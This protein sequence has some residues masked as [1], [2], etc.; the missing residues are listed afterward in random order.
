MNELGFLCTTLSAFVI[1]VT[2]GKFMFVTFLKPF[3]LDIENFV[4]IQNLLHNRS[5]DLY[6]LF[7]SKSF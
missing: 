5:V 6:G 7:T 1:A 4:S 2:I 3:Q